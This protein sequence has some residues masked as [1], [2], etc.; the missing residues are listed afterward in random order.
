MFLMQKNIHRRNA[1]AEGLLEGVR[2]KFSKEL[3]L[4]EFCSKLV[5]AWLFTG[6]APSGRGCNSGKGSTPGGRSLTESSRV[7][8]F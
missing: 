4:P 2:E 5:D 7:F 3:N 8:K 6:Y 1:A